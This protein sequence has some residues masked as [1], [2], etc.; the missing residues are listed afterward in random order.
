MVKPKIWTLALI[1]G[2]KSVIDFYE[3]EMK[4]TNKKN[5][6]YEGA[7]SLIHNT[8]SHTKCLYQIWKS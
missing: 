4:W 3:K 2:E 8:S 7:C 6:K 5:D 1:A